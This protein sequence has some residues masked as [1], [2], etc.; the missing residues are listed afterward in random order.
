MLGRWGQYLRV[1]LV[2]TDGASVVEEGANHRWRDANRSRDGVGHLRWLDV[3][4]RNSWEAPDTRYEVDDMS[5]GAWYAEWHQGAHNLGALVA[6]ALKLA[7][8]QSRGLRG[9]E[10]QTQRV[11]HDAPV[12]LIS[13]DHL[14]VEPL[15]DDGHVGGGRSN[16]LT[17]L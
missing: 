14:V 5:D 13:G 11:L 17:Q 6:K 8:Q 10:R 2:G 3:A 15:G 1:V 9:R 16:Q 7:P 12:S 4:L